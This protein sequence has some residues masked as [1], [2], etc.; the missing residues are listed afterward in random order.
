MVVI[1]VAAAAVA[2]GAA[3]AMAGMLRVAALVPPTRRDASALRRA[4]DEVARELARR[5]HGRVVTLDGTLPTD[6]Q[7]VLARARQL[8]EASRLDDAATRRSLVR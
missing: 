8:A 5:L 2:P 7:A 1:A 6:L 3:K 4:A